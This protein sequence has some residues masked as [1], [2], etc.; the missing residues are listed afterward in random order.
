MNGIN[1][2]VY[3]VGET[4]EASSNKSMPHTKMLPILPGDYI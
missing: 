1:V 3:K 4:P 2:L